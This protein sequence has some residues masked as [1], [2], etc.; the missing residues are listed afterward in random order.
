MKHE[1]AIDEGQKAISIDP[2]Y[3]DGY[4]MLSQTMRH[5]GRFEEALELIKKAM[6]LSPNPRVFY[7]ITLGWAYYQLERYEEAIPVFEHLLERCRRGECQPWLGHSGLIISY[8]GLGREEE[9]RAEAEELL[10]VDPKIS[11]E[12][13]R[14]NNFAKNPEQLERALSALRKAGLP[15]TPPLPLP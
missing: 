8:M 12:R 2:N 7:P 10:R 1:K 9:A 11:L 5:S 15:E 13:F 14:K 3:A 6:R 4:A